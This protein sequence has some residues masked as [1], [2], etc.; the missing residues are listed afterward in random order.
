MFRTEQYSKY[1]RSE[2]NATMAC[3]AAVSKSDDGCCIDTAVATLLGRNYHRLGH[4]FLCSI[5]QPT[6]RIAFTVCS[7]MMTYSLTGPGAE[8]RV[9]KV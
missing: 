3:V 6:L 1:E 9:E 7:A 2:I 5:Y 8:I 4:E